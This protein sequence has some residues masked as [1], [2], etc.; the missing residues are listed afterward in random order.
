MKIFKIASVLLTTG[1]MIFSGIGVYGTMAKQAKIIIVGDSTA[2]K[3]GYDDNYALPRAGWGMYFDKYIPD[4]IVVDN[5]AKSGRSSKSFA[6]ED[7]YN[8]MLADISQG[9]YLFIQFGHNDSKKSNDEDLA[10]RYTDPLGDINTD[11]SFKNS[12]YKNYILPAKEKGAIPVLL[13]PISRYK[14][15]DNNSAVDTHGEYDDA[16]RELANEL[17]LE[18]IDMTSETLKL[19]NEIGKNEAIKLHAI[20]KDS[21]KGSNGYDTTHLNH[22]GAY[23]IAGCIA[24]NIEH[25][26][27]L[28]ELVDE[29]KI[30]NPDFSVSR[31]DFIK[32]LVR[33]TG[34]T[35]EGT[36]F[37][38]VQN[39]EDSKIVATAKAIGLAYGTGNN[40]LS[41]N[42][43]LTLNE[44]EA[45]LSRF[46]KITGLNI[47]Y[48]SKE[49]NK[50]TCYGLYDN[51]YNI[52]TETEEGGNQSDDEIEKVE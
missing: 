5:F 7:N 25:N 20:Y 46:N 38:D 22:Y 27:T 6:A 47:S 1:A 12:L 41:P 13:T 51:I 18:C 31:L 23:V 14:F 44:C 3:Y 48:D 26:K 37:S 40:M 33:F 43:E 29:T 45:F 8:E 39:E 50:N 10:T 52:L 34:K 15:D 42:R 36:S 16:I 35:D 32:Q 49:I 28:S 2:C 30:S 11:G 19:Y 24:K 21:K 17:N 9:D 4:G